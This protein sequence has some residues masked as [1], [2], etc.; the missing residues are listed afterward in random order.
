M[1]LKI[2]SKSFCFLLFTLYAL[3]FTLSAAAANLQG[4]VEA[5]RLF[6]KDLYQEAL[7]KYESV[8][9]TG[10]GEEKLRAVYRAV[11]IEA[12]LFKYSEAVKRIFAEKLPD[13]PVWKAR[14]L[15]LRAETGREFLNQYGYSLPQDVQENAAE[16]EEKTR[17]QWLEEITS[18][19][20]QI[21]DLRAKLADISL[22]D[23]AYFIDIKDAD[24]S[25]TPTF[26][27]FI[28]LKWTDFLLS[29]PVEKEYLPDAIEFLALKYEKKFSNS[30]PRAAQAASIFEEASNPVWKIKRLLLPFTH[31]SLVRP[32]ENH[33]AARDSA[34]SILKR[35]MDLFESRLAKSEAGFEAASLLNQAGKYREAVKMCVKLEKD[36]SGTQASKKCSKIKAQ[37][38]M[39]SLNLTGRFSPPTQT[40]AAGGAP[41]NAGASYGEADPPPGKRV[42]SAT[43]RN[44][45]KV[46]FR[47]YRTSPED[48]AEKSLEQGYGRQDSWSFLKYVSPKTLEKFLLKTPDHSWSREINYKQDYGYETLDIETPS[49]EP[50]IYLAIASN[51]DGF[52][53]GSSMI[54][55]TLIN[56][57]EIML[58]GSSG[59]EGHPADFLFDPSS[60]DKQV[61]ANG[62][63]LYA[64]NALT[65]LPA[66]DIETE[67]FYRTGYNQY[68][69]ISKRADSDGKTQ[70]GVNLNLNL[71]DSYNNY[72]ID[73]L[74]RSSKGYAWWANEKSLWYSV[75]QPIE[76]FI[77]TD[78]PIYRPGQ[79]VEFKAVALVK[80]P[81]GYKVYDS[82][83]ASR[84]EGKS[85]ITVSA[86]DANYN[87]FFKKDL[88]LNQM[89]SA[90]GSFTAPAGRLLGNYQLQ[91]SMREFNR[92]FSGNA[93][94]SVEEYKRPEFEIK[95]EEAAGIWKYGEKAR[96]EG[97]VK[98]Y[99]GGAVPDAAVN[100]K[101]YRQRY[102]P[103]F[104]W[105]WRWFYAPSSRQEISAG[106]V[107]TDSSGKFS[108]EFI[109]N[110]ENESHKGYPSSFS[111]EI[112][113]RDAGGRT[114]TASK[115]YN[116]G[117]K[118]YLFDIKPQSGFLTEGKASGIFLRL[119][120]LNEKQVSG[121]A[122][123]EIFRI[124]GR[125]EY[126]GHDE[127]YYGHIS[128]NPS[129]EEAF[130]NAKNG[131]KVLSGDVKFFENKPSQV[132]L[133]GLSE[134]VY[135]FAV[136]IHD[137]FGG[138]TEQSIIFVCSPPA[139]RLRRTG[140]PADKKNSLE[141]PPLTVA[142]HSS[143]RTGETAKVLLGSSELKGVKYVEIWK[144]NFFLSSA[145]IK[146]PGAGVFEMPVEK[147]HK[148][149]FFVKWFGA[150]DF[151]IR[152]GQVKIEVPEPER[153]LSLNLKYDKAVE[154]GQKVSWTLFAKDSNKK[155]SIGEALVRIF[156]RSLE[157][158]QKE[159]EQW[160]SSLYMDHSAPDSEIFSIF[161]A[162]L[163]SI[164]IKQ[165]WIKIMMDLFRAFIREPEMPALRINRSRIHRGR[166][167]F[168]KGLEVS[169]MISSAAG[170][171]GEAEG[172][173]MRMEEKAAR[174]PA[175]APARG[176]AKQKAIMQDT[177]QEMERIS[178]RKDFSE[179]A[180]FKPHL[181]I[182]QG[183]GSFSFRMPEKLTSWKIR[184]Y[185]LTP[186]V[187]RGVMSFETVTRKEL[188][189]RVEMP[190]FFREKDAGQI[191]A[192]VS[193]ETDSEISGEL[194]LVIEKHGKKAHSE[195]YLDE[196]DLMK[197]FIIKPRSVFTGTWDITVPSGITVFSVKAVARAGEKTDAE[198]RELPILPSRQRLIKTVFA[199]MDGTVK[200]TLELVELKKE[201]STRENENMALQIDPQLALTVLNSMPLLVQYPYECTEQLVNRYTPLAIVNSFYKKY[202]GLKEAVK[203]I[204]K[205]TTVTPAWN[206]EDPLRLMTLME[207]PWENISKGRESYWPV[208]DLFE[209]GFVETQM[210]DALQKLKTYQLP[211]GSFPWFPGGYPS[212]HM[213]LYALEAF[214]QA[215]KYGVA[216][217]E[218]MA[219]RAVSYVNSEIPKYMKPDPASTSY[220]LY[221][222]Y[223]LTSFPKSWPETQESFKMAKVWVEFA[224]KYS[225]AMTPFGKAY[226]AWVYMRLNEKTKAYSYLDR[227]MDG[228]KEDP[229]TGLYWAPEKISWLWYNDTVEKHAFILRT[230]LFLKPKDKRIEPMLKWLLFNR[231]GNEWKS[232]RTT[233]AAV[234]SILDILKTRGALDKPDNYS[235]KW[236]DENYAVKVEPFEWIEKPF[237]FYK[238]G[239]DISQKHSNA[240]I[241]KEGP[242]FGFASLTLVFTTD[243]LAESSGPG[244]MELN[245]QYF[246][247]YKEGDDYR[248]RP[249]KSGD[250]VKVG[251]QIEVHLTANAK[252][253]FEYVHLKDPKPAGFEAEEL[254]SGWKW[255]KL[256]RYEEPRDSLTNFFMDWLPHG[257]YV[258]K[259]RIRPT[260]PGKYRIG[261]SVMQ[262]MYSPEFSAYSS[263]MEI[264]VIPD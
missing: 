119:M 1:N 233:A 166:F 138:T 69:K 160:V 115:T 101:I 203:K 257:E 150:S 111:I 75:P 198:Q 2:S 201:D 247:R 72:S 74:A 117:S 246:L 236:A 124:D 245:R 153:E 241:E 49:L 261:S 173:S 45:P 242:G 62:F 123:Y 184:G 37:I 263:G 189:A 125:P 220:I 41:Q 177:A 221:A 129:L 46:F 199:T 259:Y 79:K 239:R 105:W 19:Y 188:M 10:A 213:T 207:T 9:K 210:Q 53:P 225:K 71:N 15:L 169:A 134:G 172:G 175:T 130:K 232:T 204:P 200:K 28:V 128:P 43:L 30:Q 131:Q 154:P 14:F 170:R 182:K 144:G 76:I 237:R 24:I 227:A 94:F 255:D 146:E 57:T 249:L 23:E 20:E 219:K 178:A 35:W 197:N 244:I 156:D 122:V 27:D 167:S 238:T 97:F 106:N 18:S 88:V 222:S 110:P 186:D 191:K 55:G 16:P 163:T 113:A 230:L 193:N 87:E 252:S 195:F 187:K 140:G 109:P 92:N 22:K 137:P 235:M 231:K 190:R 228:S 81:Q 158:Y 135:R 34:V 196:K 82:H 251:D 120:N 40:T 102:V 21:W 47:L 84:G 206:R 214:A 254:K 33:G 151:E 108:F 98:Y 5:D 218:N 99:F 136:K 133:S 171:L 11:E 52:T 50:G 58:I 139:P 157:Y 240:V 148:G 132:K 104:C 86:R 8:I 126:P 42:L 180:F 192:L 48:L 142:E 181:A 95:L 60:P 145:I 91:A 161:H 65:G 176:F 66:P 59:L 90:S 77:E 209:P 223:V 54:Q 26:W 38:E 164:Q 114:I 39:P 256:S 70:V 107:K 162:P 44:I 152:G 229:N 3:L 217:D 67:I 61:S 226:A 143:Y 25:Y 185:A 216:V 64:V 83:A 205:R 141:L 253:Q 262:S 211:D 12:L 6:E 248:L 56:I 168:A 73:P 149:G 234:Y 93:S 36:H 7:E 89:G 250:A 208:I 85:K 179:T 32:F 116:A 121:N 118:A 215:G 112:E 165:G 103:W 183:R 29:E 202:P 80:T 63:H 17:K 243:R 13:D 194:L 127:H 258:L 96:V 31:S 159:D 4:L 155:P 224:D 212:L 78:R 51:E 264:K 174:S 260:T 100:Y 68:E 147:K